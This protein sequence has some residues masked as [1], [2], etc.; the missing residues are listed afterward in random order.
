MA[1]EDDECDADAVRPAWGQIGRVATLAAIAA[2]SKLYLNLL[3]TTTIAGEDRFH[4]AA[5]ERDSD[6]GLLTVSNH[7]RCVRLRIMTDVQTVS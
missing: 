2:A 5:L 4:K 3:N 6:Q 1:V 7:T